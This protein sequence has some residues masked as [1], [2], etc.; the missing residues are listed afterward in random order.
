[1]GK[2]HV[3][4]Q[5]F[6]H[7]G[8]VQI[9]APTHKCPSKVQTFKGLHFFFNSPFNNKIFFCENYNDNFFKPNIKTSNNEKNR[10]V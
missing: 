3:E 6:E 2:K 7:V 5:L 10:Q 1:M 9:L 8:G 4:K